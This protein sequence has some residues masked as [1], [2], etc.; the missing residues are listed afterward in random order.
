MK[1]TQMINFTN[2]VHINRSADE[3]YGYLSDL[4]HTPEWNWAITETR[5]ITP[6]P[7]AIGTRYRQTRSV[8]Q[9]STEALEITGLKPSQLIEIQGTLAQFSAQLSYH[10]RETHGGTELTNTVHLEPQRALR[11]IAPVLV[12]R[13]KRAVGDNLNELRARL[14]A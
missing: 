5:K 7:P 10:L 13:I 8:P 12:G 14:E 2:V 11:F 4:E 3:V 9:P 1:G 6:G